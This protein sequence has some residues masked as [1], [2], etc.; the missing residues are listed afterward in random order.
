MTQSLPKTD[1]SSKLE[2]YIGI[3]LKTP[4]FEPAALQL[5]SS[6]FITVQNQIIA[7]FEPLSVRWDCSCHTLG[8][9][10]T[11]ESLEPGKFDIRVT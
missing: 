5:A 11:A 8:T 1:V 4:D 6:L 7:L 9:S 10:S 2:G 3:S